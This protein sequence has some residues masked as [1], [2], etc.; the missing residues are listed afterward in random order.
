MIQRKNKS[1]IA[2][3]CAALIFLSLLMIFFRVY[4]PILDIR[5]IN[6]SI[7]IS[8]KGGF[9]LSKDTLNFGM[10]TPGSSASRN[11]ILENSYSFR[12]RVD[13]APNWEMSRFLKKEVF[14]I[15]RA[16]NKTFT[17]NAFVPEEIEHGNYTGTVLIKIR[18]DI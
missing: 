9:D 7:I 15:E 12:I 14:Y 2:V 18:K 16:E 4:N 13:I 10:V 11:I 3:F 17:I 1:L 8:D 6:S 5:Q